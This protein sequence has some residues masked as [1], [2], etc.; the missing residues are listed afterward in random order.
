MIHSYLLLFFRFMMRKVIKF[1]GT[2]LFKMKKISRGMK[3]IN[4]E[5]RGK[6]DLTCIFFSNQVA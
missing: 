5:E 4:N 1:H 3:S 2:L 6:R